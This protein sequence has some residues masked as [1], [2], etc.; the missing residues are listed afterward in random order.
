MCVCCMCE[1]VRVREEDQVGDIAAE[2][3][4][5]DVQES[6]RILHVRVRQRLEL[7]VHERSSGVQSTAHFECWQKKKKAVGEER[8]MSVMLL[9]Q[10]PEMSMPSSIGNGS[11]NER[12]VFRLMKVKMA[13]ACVGHI[14]LAQCA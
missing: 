11:E 12:M 7:H 8:T 6:H 5:P 9:T 3:E 14:K 10:K 13:V 4:R 2:L 1:C